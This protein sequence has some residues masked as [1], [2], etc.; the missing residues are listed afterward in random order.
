MAV[1]VDDV[2]DF[3]SFR[4]YEGDGDVVGFADVVDQD[5]YVVEVPDRGL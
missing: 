3:L 1:D 5:A 2:P 4:V